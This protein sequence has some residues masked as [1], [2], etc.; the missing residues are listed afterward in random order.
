MEYNMDLYFT[1]KFAGTWLQFL[2][3]WPIFIII[4]LVGT[5]VPFFRLVMTH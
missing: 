4:T 1:N 3:A 2:V 5:I